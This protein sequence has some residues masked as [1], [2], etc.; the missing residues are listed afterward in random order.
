MDLK[1]AEEQTVE[2]RSQNITKGYKHS[3]IINMDETG[4][5]IKQFRAEHMR[6]VTW[7]KDKQDEV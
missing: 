7:I 6:L 1:I 5:F 4:F 2:F 3:N